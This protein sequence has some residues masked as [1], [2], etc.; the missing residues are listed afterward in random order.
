M[1]GINSNVSVI[2]INV[3]GSNAPGKRKML[4]DKIFF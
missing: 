3:K 2:T 1:G 4:S